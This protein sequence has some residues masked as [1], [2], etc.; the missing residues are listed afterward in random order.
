MVHVQYTKFDSHAAHCMSNANFDRVTQ[1]KLKNTLM[2]RARICQLRCEVYLMY[3]CTYYN[4]YVCMYVCMSVC[5]YAYM[6]VRVYI[7]YTYL[8]IYVVATH[9]RT[10]G[11]CIYAAMHVQY[12]HIIIHMHACMH[13]HTCICKICIILLK[14]NITLA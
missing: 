7:H 8:R 14:V 3:V 13:V 1:Q 4:M 11:V 2:F 10:Y 9:V 12:A 5:M 6:H